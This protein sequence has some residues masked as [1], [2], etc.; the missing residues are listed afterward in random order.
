MNFEDYMNAS[1]DLLKELFDE[2]LVKKLEKTKLK[3]IDWKGADVTD[4]GITAC[5]PNIKARF[6]KDWIEY[7]GERDTTA[8][9]L[10][11]QSVFHYGYQQ[12]VDVSNKNKPNYDEIFKRIDEMHKSK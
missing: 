1:K 6:T 9:D 7:F 8:L 4:S 3:E 10:F 2:E 11:L 5:T 12:G